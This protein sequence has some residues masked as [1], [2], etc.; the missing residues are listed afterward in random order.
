M[1][2][3]E[4]LKYS[5]E[6]MEGGRLPAAAG[7]LEACARCRG[8]VAELERIAQTAN[9]LGTETLEPPARVWFALR[10][11]LES[12]GLIRQEAPI[13]WLAGLFAAL[14]RPALA[15][16]YVAVLLAALVLGSISLTP[17]QDATSPDAQL[18]SQFVPAEQQQMIGL[19]AHD[20]A[21]T[22][23]YRDNLAVVDKFIAMC[24]KTVREDPQNEIARDYLYAAFQQKADLLASMTERGSGGE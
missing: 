5:E 10:A 20:P 9:E 23:S 18:Q 7:H 21:V 6:W 3:N 11:Q 22:A 19:H 12:E 2:C 14:P 24:E 8:L 13:S 4:F 16:A 15:G 17:V 1:Q